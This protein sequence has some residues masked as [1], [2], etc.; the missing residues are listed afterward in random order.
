MGTTGSWRGGVIIEGENDK[1]GWGMIITIIKNMGTILH[2][3]VGCIHTE[4]ANWF[5]ERCLKFFC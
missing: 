4:T 1:G 5:A 3:P 2:G